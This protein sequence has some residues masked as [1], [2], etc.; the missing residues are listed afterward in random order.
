MQL[1][2][3][4]ETRRLVGHLLWA[5]L[6][7]SGERG[8]LTPGRLVRCDRGSEMCRLIHDVIYVYLYIM[9]SK[10]RLNDLSYVSRRMSL[11]IVVC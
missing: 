11:D 8:G 7:Y 1:S 6:T 4:V 10:R 2:H 9:Y 5:G 3:R